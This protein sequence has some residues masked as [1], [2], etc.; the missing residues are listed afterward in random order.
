MPAGTASDQRGDPTAVD[1]RDLRME[2]GRLDPDRGT[3]LEIRSA[4][5]RAV[6]GDRPHSGAAL[7]FCYRGPSQTAEPLASGEL[8]RQIGLKLRAENTCNVVYVMWH[9][10]PTS[11]VHVSVK[12][13]PNLHAHSECGDRGYINLPGPSTAIPAI[14]EGEKHSL[15]ARIDGDVLQV[16]A[17]GALAWEGHLPPEAFAFDGP[18]G[19]RSDNGDFDAELRVLP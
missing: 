2:C 6:V 17:D 1:A 15:E 9:V 19:I 16:K 7:S 10:A 11:G 8:R 14:R 5:V 18:V 12:W 13:N 4:C 3:R